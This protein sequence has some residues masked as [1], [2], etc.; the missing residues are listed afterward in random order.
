MS[1]NSGP[2]SSSLQKQHDAFK[3]AM[4]S[5]TIIPKR[6]I[7]SESAN[8]DAAEG[9]L[10]SKS[11]ISSPLLSTNSAPSF[12]LIKPHRTETHS[13]RHLYSY[14]HAVLSYLRMVQRE[15]SF[16]Q[17]KRDIGVDLAANGALQQALTGNPKVV[18]KELQQTL[19]Y[20]PNFVIHSK[21]DLLRLL[22]NSPTEGIEF[23]D[24]RDSNSSI[25]A[26][27]EQLSAERLVLILRADAK[28]ESSASRSLFFNEMPNVRAV[29]A[30]FRDAWHSM[31]LPHEIDIQSELSAAGYKGVA[32]Q[33]RSDDASAKRSAS[34]SAKKNTKKT[35][36]P[37]KITNTH[38][39][40]LVDF[41]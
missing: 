31:T 28:K 12:E 10:I 17:L 1:S 30:E 40:G 6:N 29:D 38:L 4:K 18:Y 25:E 15:V 21:A 24:L 37:V 33:P 27:V 36:R 23:E 34:G 41:S 9:D 5:N 22:Q 8:L 26:F 13:E 3:K 19:S 16:E 20:K 11:Q 14:L 7:H 2:Q 35:R 32:V 39:E